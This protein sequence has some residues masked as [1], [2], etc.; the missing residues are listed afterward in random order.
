MKHKTYGYIYIYIIHTYK[1]IIIMQHIQY[2]NTH[3]QA[4]IVQHNIQMQHLKR[5]EFHSHFGPGP[6]SHMN[7]E[8]KETSYIIPLRSATTRT[9]NLKFYAERQSYPWLAARRHRCKLHAIQELSGHCEHIKGYC[10]MTTHHVGH[11]VYLFLYNWV[12]QTA[13]SASYW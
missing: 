5:N 1:I 13:L 10:N 2:Y 7:Q 4:H 8:P 6:Y 11:K 9:F 12:A 3:E